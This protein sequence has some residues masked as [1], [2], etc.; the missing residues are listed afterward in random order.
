MEELRTAT[1]KTF[2]CDYFNPFPPAGQVN[3]RVLESSLSEVAA[4]FG[5]PTETVQ[6]FCGKQYLAHF[7]RV[8]AIVP[9]VDA[10][11]VIM[12]KE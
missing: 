12:G 5:N 8:V 1:G 7:S 9:E 6:I 11:R 4:V 10:I 3:F 2:K